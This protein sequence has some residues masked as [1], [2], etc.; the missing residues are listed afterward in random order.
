VYPMIVFTNIKP[1]YSY[2]YCVT[3]YRTIV[4]VVIDIPH[5]CRH[6]SESFGYALATKPCSLRM[7]K[8]KVSHQPGHG[9]QLVSVMTD[10]QVAD[11]AV[12]SSCPSDKLIKHHVVKTYGGVEA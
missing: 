6:R 5:I 9:S 4:N 7:P 8:V 10:N 11:W 1:I 3:R 2:T 12:R